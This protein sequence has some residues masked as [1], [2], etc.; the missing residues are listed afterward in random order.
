MLTDLNRDPSLLAAGQCLCDYVSVVHGFVLV[1]RFPH[2]M[3]LDRRGHTE[4]RHVTR[5][6]GWILLV[7][8]PTAGGVDE[9]P[10]AS[11]HCRVDHAARTLEI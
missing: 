2:R 8:N 10:L 5:G 3:V 1:G 9:M 6:A 11:T 7:V 4:R